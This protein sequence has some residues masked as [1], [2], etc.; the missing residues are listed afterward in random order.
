MKL[1]S[2]R[3]HGFNQPPP[4][5]GVSRPVR[6]WLVVLLLLAASGPGVL[7][8]GAQPDTPTPTPGTNE[9][10]VQHVDPDET[11][12]DGDLSA[13][14]SSLARRM[15]ARLADSSIQLSQGQ[16]EAA[17]QLVGEEYQDQYGKYVEVAGETDEGPQS[18]TFATA[19][20]N[21][22]QLARDVETYRETL[23]A[24][25]TARRNGNEQRARRLAREL[26]AL[27]TNI[28]TT[29]TT[30]VGS[31]ETLETESGADLSDGQ[32]VINRTVENVTTTQAEIR[33]AT[34]TATSLT[35]SADAETASFAAPLVLTGELTTENGTALADR[36]V[37][38]R[39]GEQTLQ[40]T[41]DADGSFTVEYRPVTRPVGETDVTLRYVPNASSV[42]LGSKTSVSVTITQVTPALQVE[43][44]TDRVGFGETV[45]VTGRVTAAEMSVDGVPVVMTV[46][47]QQIATGTTTDGTFTLLGLLPAGVAAGTAQV[48]VRIPLEDRAIA[49]TT[50]TRSLQVM[51]TA[52]DL[53]VRAT[54]S[55]STVQLRGRL[56]TRDGTPVSGQ[57]LTL[58]RNGSVVETV[59]TTAGGTYTA[60]LAGEPETAYRVRV[61]YDDSSTNLGPAN[62]TTVVTLL[63]SAGATGD[64]GASDSSII[65][66]LGATVTELPLLALFGAGL[67]FALVAG[68]VWLWRREET[69]GTAASSDGVVTNS[70]PT[71]DSADSDAALAAAQAALAEDADVAVE[72]GYTRIRQ[73][74]QARGLGSSA[75]THWEF[76]RACVAAGLTGTDALE[77]L[78]QLYEQAA[79]GPAGVDRA[80]A[81]A[82]LEAATQLLE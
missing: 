39:I 74:L 55:E 14:Q 17:D 52:T 28:S 49:G 73:Q 35:V 21:Q 54:A 43:T 60:Q 82:A 77:Q 36:R 1:A 33:A 67:V 65:A 38:F 30:L 32:Q 50:T 81:E 7:L 12:A 48:Q 10:T 40:T 2:R 59:Q 18:E 24:Y 5:T 42:Y 62:A 58:V 78:T 4:P 53:S 11:S 76:Y 25:R 46:G 63:P 9:T 8:A 29:E 23:E 34:F 27:A 68:A 20:Q 26:N 22:R 71:A 66:Q 79:F 70:V 47:G 6:L 15:A 56:T 3:G 57:E 75:A 80:A 16:Y 45:R 61:Q 37:Q 13:L 51:E 41:T 64:T 72:R 31:Y 19:Q 69:S 44:V